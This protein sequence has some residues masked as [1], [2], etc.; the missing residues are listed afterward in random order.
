MIETKE[1][2]MNPRPLT[3]EKFREH[4]YGRI[5]EALRLG[6]DD[7][8]QRLD[9]GLYLVP[10]TTQGDMV[11]TVTGTEP[12]LDCTCEAQWHMPLCKHRA[13][14]LIRR[15]KEA[16]SLIAETEEGGLVVVTKEDAVKLAYPISKWPALKWDA[17]P[18]TDA[19]LI[20][21]LPEEGTG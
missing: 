21:D 18:F 9:H 8:V 6:L 13:A 14:V 5:K 11:Y 4:V 2:G 16:G 17:P 20:L 7:S 15:W 1:K 19:D 12:P 3:P 10:S